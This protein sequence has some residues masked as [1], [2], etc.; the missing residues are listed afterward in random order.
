MI[1]SMLDTFRKILRRGIGISVIGA[2]IGLFA[3]SALG[4][5][6]APKPVPVPPPGPLVNPAPKFSQWTIGYFYLQDRKGHRNNLLPLAPD[7]PR[8]VVTTKTGN[9]IHEQIV[10]IAGDTFDKWQ[11]GEAIF[12]KPL[13]QAYWG[14]QDPNPE[15]DSRVTDNTALPLPASGFR[16]LDWINRVAYG[17]TIQQNNATYFL[18]VFPG[19]AD[20]DFSSQAKLDAQNKVAYIDASTRLPI[21]LRIG[22]VTR[23]Y[24]YSNPPTSMQVLP[25]DLAAEIEQGKRN[26]AIISSAPAKEY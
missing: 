9:I 23:T 22:D 25:G 2:A 18:F 3:A 13:G 16:D 12:T 14:E 1:Q 7:A 5:E 15:S 19:S 24:T 4:Q 11:V 21:F 20:M 6:S 26:R 10:R 8:K 17:G